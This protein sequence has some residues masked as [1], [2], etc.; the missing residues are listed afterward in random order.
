MP[1]DWH[2]SSRFNCTRA[3]VGPSHALV[4]TNQSLPWV[5]MGEATSGVHPSV[6]S[7]RPDAR[8]REQ[9]TKALPGIQVKYLHRSH[10]L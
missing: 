7:L 5:G 8:R 2:K 9:H 1:V 3:K 4:L 6:A 10:D